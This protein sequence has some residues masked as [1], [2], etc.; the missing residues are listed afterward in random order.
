MPSHRFSW[1]VSDPSQMELPSHLLENGRYVVEVRDGD[2]YVFGN[3]DGLLYLAEVIAR[4][5]LGGYA[6]GFHI[7]LPMDS[8][9]EPGEAADEIAVFAAS[10]VSI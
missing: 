8:R 4:C 3:R 9:A 2:V 5:A 7:H 6:E 10:E 1:V